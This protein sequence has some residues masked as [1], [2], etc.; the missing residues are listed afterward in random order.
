MPCF[1]NSDDF[2][3]LFNWFQLNL[4]WKIIK[5]N[6]QD[7]VRTGQNWPFE[8]GYRWFQLHFIDFQLFYFLTRIT[9]VEI[10][11]SWVIDTFYFNQI[12]LFSVTSVYINLHIL[13]KMF[14]RI[15]LVTLLQGYSWSRKIWVY[16]QTVL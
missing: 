11:S 14:S 12:K 5:K 7:V 16:Y 10:S 8:R 2:F 13:I 1:R 15:I 3:Q 4:L 6:L 9:P